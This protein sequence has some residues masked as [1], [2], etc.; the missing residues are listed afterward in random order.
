[1]STV[2]ASVESDSPEKP[3]G[4]AVEIVVVRK[5]DEAD[6]AALQEFA[7]VMLK[8]LVGRNAI[9]NP[10][11]LRDQ[12]ATAGTIPVLIIRVNRH[13]AVR[14]TGAPPSGKSAYKAVMRCAEIAESERRKRQDAGSFE[15]ITLTAR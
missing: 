14:I 5:S 12:I 10:A 4:Q 2:T 8:E 6:E 15:I 1:M 9:L 13:P 7:R 11:P 3:D